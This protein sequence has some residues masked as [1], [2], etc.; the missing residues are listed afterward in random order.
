MSN[1]STWNITEKGLSQFDGGTNQICIEF[2]VHRLICKSGFP[3][4]I[5]I[6]YQ[7]IQYDK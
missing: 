1:R 7:Y 2:G 5:L 3:Y 4:F 6:P